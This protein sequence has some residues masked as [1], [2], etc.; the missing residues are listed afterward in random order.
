MRYARLLTA[1]ALLLATAAAA[2]QSFACL[3]KEE[4][5]SGLYYTEVQTADG[6]SQAWHCPGSPGQINHRTMLAGFA[7][8]QA[9]VSA[10][11]GALAQWASAASARLGVA[12]AVLS[13]CRS[14]PAAGT[15]E[16]VRYD[17]LKASAMVA[18]QAKYDA[19]HPATGPVWRTP[20]AGSFTLYRVTN[21]ARVP[22]TGRTATPRALCDCVRAKLT[23]SPV[24]GSVST[25]CTL[26]TGPADE[27]T[28]CQQVAQ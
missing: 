27:V 25:F 12:N 14:I 2:A 23:Y 7:P 1:A 17:A 19:D 21:G 11:P 22:I 18:V 9:C 8:L 24:P 20:A 3:P 16:R 13:A 6:S 4:G 10:V 15:P 5:G 26:A 28:L